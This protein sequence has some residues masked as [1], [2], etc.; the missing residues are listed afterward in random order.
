[1]GQDG[2]PITVTPLLGSCLRPSLRPLVRDD[3]GSVLSGN[4]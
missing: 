2:Y 3:G 4:L 1:M